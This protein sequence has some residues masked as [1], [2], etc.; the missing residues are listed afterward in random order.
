MDLPCELKREILVHVLRRRQPVCRFRSDGS[1]DTRE[2]PIDVKVFAVSRVLFADAVRIFYEENMFALKSR[3]RR[4]RDH[5][6]LFVSQSMRD[7]LPRPTYS[8]TRMYINVE[9][10][11][12]GPTLSPYMDGNQ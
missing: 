1:A 9:V 4:Y 7:Q 12:A 11:L 6:S 10:E 5:L 2:R 3:D 8:I